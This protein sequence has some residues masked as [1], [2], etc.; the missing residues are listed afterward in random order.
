MRESWE[1]VTYLRTWAIIPVLL[2]AVVVASP[3]QT[4]TTLAS[5]DQIDGSTP[6]HM[7]L[8]QGFDGDFYGTSYLGGSPG[9]GTIFRITSTD[10]LTTVYSFCQDDCHDGSN[11]WSGLV[12]ASNGDFYG[13][14]SSGGGTELARYSESTPQAHYQGFIVFAHIMFGIAWTAAVLRQVWSEPTGETS[15]GRLGAVGP[16]VM[17]RSSKPPLPASSRHFIA[18]A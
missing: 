12:L 16:A 4:F 7:F 9:P 5:F 2:A 18:F 10:T 14:T 13:T 17:G 3:G 8:T 1:R 6:Y 11:P 15:T